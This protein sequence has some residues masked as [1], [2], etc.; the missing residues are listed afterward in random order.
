MSFSQSTLKVSNDY[1]LRYDI[2]IMIPPILALAKYE[3]MTPQIQES[4]KDFEEEMEKKLKSVEKLNDVRNRLLHL[5]LV[6]P[7]QSQEEKAYHEAL[8][9]RM[10]SGPMRLEQFNEIKKEIDAIRNT[11]EQIESK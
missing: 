6:N 2:F 5:K 11:P 10:A 7:K 1:V 9:E 8:Y 4:S 3:S